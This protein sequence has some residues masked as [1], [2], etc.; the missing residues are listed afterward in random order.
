[1]AVDPLAAQV[2][3]C[4]VAVTWGN[5]LAPLVEGVTHTCR[6]YLWDRCEVLTV[7]NALPAIAENV[8]RDGALASSMQVVRKA[9]FSIRGHEAYRHERPAGRAWTGNQCRKSGWHREYCQVIRRR[10]RHN[11]MSQLE[12]RNRDW[13]ALA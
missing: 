8:A 12:N 6:S 13:E 9:P 3:N 10:Q 1:M 11:D 5:S 7:R 4:R 2:S